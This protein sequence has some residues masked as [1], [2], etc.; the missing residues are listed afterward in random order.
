MKSAIVA[1]LCIAFAKRT[2]GQTTTTY[3]TGIGHGT[4]LIPTVHSEPPNTLPAVAVT[5]T[6]TRS[7]RCLSCISPR[8]RARTSRRSMSHCE[9]NMQM[10]RRTTSPVVL[11]QLTCA[12]SAH[13]FHTS[14]AQFEFV[15]PFQFKNRETNSASRSLIRRRLSSSNLP[16]SRGPARILL[17]NRKEACYGTS[18]YRGY[19]QRTR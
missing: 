17:V 2:P 6:T 11:N 15:L 7:R 14:E 5:W 1:V 9:I 13:H 10:E 18:N 12:L 3:D 16:G 8:T 19:L 4:P